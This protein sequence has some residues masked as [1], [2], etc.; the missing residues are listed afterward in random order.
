VLENTPVNPLYGK[1]WAMLD[2]NWYWGQP[3]VH[4]IGAALDVTSAT[5]LLVILRAAESWAPENDNVTHPDAILCREGRALVQYTDGS[6]Q[7]LDRDAEFLPNMSR[8][9]SVTNL[10]TSIAELLLIARKTG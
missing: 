3:G 1:G 2:T 6:I 10:G 4:D 5:I 8:L 7:Q 9:L